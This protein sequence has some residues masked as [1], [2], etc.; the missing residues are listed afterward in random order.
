M[1][2]I[3][4]D[5]H[6][7]VSSNMLPYEIQYKKDKD[8]FLVLENYVNF[9]KGCEKFVRATTDYKNYVAELKL[10]GFT[11]CQVLGEI[12]SQMGVPGHNVTVEM[13]HG[14]I[15]TLFDYCAA[16]MTHL[17]KKGT[18][19]RTPLVASIVMDEHW[20]GH[21]QTVFLSKTAHQAVDSGKLFINLKQAYGNLNEFLKKYSDGFTEH[22]IN[23][24][25]QYITLSEENGSTDNGLFELKDTIYDWSNRR[26]KLGLSDK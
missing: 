5:E 25:N 17:L 10:N 3:V 26:A 11:R 24:I 13:H 19:V 22:Q 20:A 6:G 4:Y 18:R 8:F 14:P 9:I 2:N 23:K 21:V 15:L 7:S 1:L 16:V 12:D